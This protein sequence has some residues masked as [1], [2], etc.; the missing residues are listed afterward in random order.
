M[1]GAVGLLVPAAASASRAPR[2]QQRLA[3]VAVSQRIQRA[4]GAEPKVGVSR[5]RV[6][7]DGRWAL[8]TVTLHYAEGPPD[9][10][11]AIYHVI[12]GHWTVTAHSPGTERTQCG[13]GMPVSAMRELGLTPSCPSAGGASAIAVSCSRVVKYDGGNFEGGFYRYRDMSCGE[14][15]SIVR[16]YLE[17]NRAPRGFRCSEVS[18]R[19]ARPEGAMLCTSGEPLVEFASE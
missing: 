13:I 5:L 6:T 9:S 17:H 14:A 1:L 4:P 11:L 10:A 15:R 2:P 16:E 12:R 8:A 7:D 18:P 19:S 3:I